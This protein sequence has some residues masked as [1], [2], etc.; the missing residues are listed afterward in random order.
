MV[1]CTGCTVAVKKIMPVQSGVQP[2]RRNHRD[3]LLSRVSALW[4]GGLLW[5]PR[6]Q[7]GHLAHK[8][9]ST[10]FQTDGFSSGIERK[11]TQREPADPS[12]SIASSQ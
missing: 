4:L 3:K 8:T 10:N 1:S 12:S 2:Q 9:H 11:R 5:M 7:E 6:W